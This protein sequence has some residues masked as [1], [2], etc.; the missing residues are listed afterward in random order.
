[1]VN[2]TSLKRAR[3]HYQTHILKTV[4]FPRFAS[5][6]QGSGVTTIWPWNREQLLTFR[7]G[8]CVGV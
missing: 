4:C 5:V 8:F 3:E 2:K 7:V 1:M 6:S